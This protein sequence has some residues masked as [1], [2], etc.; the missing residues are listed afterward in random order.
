V[1]AV[2]V[3]RR[4]CREARLKQAGSHA[5]PQSRKD[6]NA[7]AENLID[8]VIQGKKELAE[9]AFAINKFFG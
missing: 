6:E 5:K 9:S 2:S 4:N 7:Q 1:I 3:T 8:R